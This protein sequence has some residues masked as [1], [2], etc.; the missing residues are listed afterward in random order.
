MKYE[1]EWILHQLLGKVGKKNQMTS[2]EKNEQ[3]MNM[4][5]LENK[6]MGAG[7]TNLCDKLKIETF[8]YLR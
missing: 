7:E 4:K 6:N 1:G 5:Q 2:F 8:K 3:F